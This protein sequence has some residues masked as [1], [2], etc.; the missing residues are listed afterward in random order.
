MYKSKVKLLYF[1]YLGKEGEAISKEKSS[2][3]I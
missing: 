2:P 3:G 1:A